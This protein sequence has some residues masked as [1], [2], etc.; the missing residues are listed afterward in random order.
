MPPVLG[1][2]ISIPS[3]TLLF[4]VISPFVLH[5][6][7]WDTYA[8]L[9]FCAVGLL[10]PATVTLLSFEANRRMGPNTAG[11]IGNLAPL[12]AVLFAIVTLGEAL[13][14]LQAVGIAAIVVHHPVFMRGHRGREPIGSVAR[15]PHDDGR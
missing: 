12:F 10:F 4:W 9:I 8:A 1:G 7:A 11:A 15:V 14:P 5:F 3:A 2:A 13:R 6:G